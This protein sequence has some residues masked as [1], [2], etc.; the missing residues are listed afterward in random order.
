MSLHLL[1]LYKEAPSLTNHAPWPAIPSHPPH[2]VLHQWLE[3]VD[4]AGLVKGAAQG[5]GLGNAFLSHIRAIDGIIHVLRA[6][7]DPDIIHVEDRVD[8]IG[9]IEI[10]TNELRAKDLE[11]VARRKVSPSS[12]SP[13]PSSSSCPSS[14][15]I[16]QPDFNAREKSTRWIN[17]EREP[18]LALGRLTSTR[19]SRA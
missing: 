12:S 7:D 4:I 1:P 18:K 16:P 9:D 3:I 10:I 13:P 8:P 6:F 11:A 17:P 2:L 15:H 5:A 14:M 19:R